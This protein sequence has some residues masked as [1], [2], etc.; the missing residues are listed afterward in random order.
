MLLTADMLNVKGNGK[1]IQT[2][3]NTSSNKVVLLRDI[4]NQKK[5]AHPADNANADDD[6]LQF[7][8]EVK[9]IRDACVELY[10]DDQNELQGIFFQDDR[11][12][13][14][15]RAYPDLLLI[16]ATYGVNNRRMPLFLLVV[17]DGNGES[18]IVALFL[19]RTENYETM[20]KL[21]HKF[22]VENNASD[23]LSLVITDKNFAERK[24]LSDSFP[25]VQLQLCIFHALQA[26][27]REITPEKRE[28]SAADKIVVIRILRKM[29][30]S[31]SETIYFRL[32][33]QLRGLRLIK[34]TEYIDEHWHPVRTE[35]AACFTMKYHHYSNRTTNRV[36][37][38]NSKL[39]SVVT[40][41]TT[42]QKF[43]IETIQ[44]MK[45]AITESDYR[46]ISKAERQPIVDGNEEEYVRKYRRLLTEFA[47]FKLKT[48][49]E[50]H[51][52]IV[53]SNITREVGI[54]TLQTNG[55][56]V[57]YITKSDTCSC[58]FFSVLDMPCKHMLAFWDHHQL[59]KYVPEKCAARWYKT[60]LPKEISEQVLSLEFSNKPDVHKNV[61]TQNMKFRKAIETSKIIAA[62]LSQKPSQVFDLFMKVLKQFEQFIQNN[63]VFSIH[64]VGI[65]SIS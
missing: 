57:I 9:K 47:F 26:F 32:Y 22:K 7:M 14:Y 28:I 43:F 33:E 65:V 17:M 50:M 20:M 45:S 55:Q 58:P 42:L 1:L 23:K 13:Q 3:M 59:P 64:S 11:M 40:K 27:N 6:L 8:D 18:Q 48:H 19:T 34:V 24:A 36:E 30:F 63:D 31:E 37:L 41:Y 2:Q 15:F 61:L 53:F 12:K 60:N 44:F 21:F 56:E 51:T 10:T 5:R 52:S 49:I 4:H 38:L 35:W 25:G 29:V 46:S 54:T 39:K 16:D 62:A